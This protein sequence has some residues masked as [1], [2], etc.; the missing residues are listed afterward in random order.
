MI[1]N[2]KKKKKKAQQKNSLTNG[3]AS[4]INNNLLFFLMKKRVSEAGDH[5]VSLKV[6][7]GQIDLKL[8]REL[9]S[10]IKICLIP[11]NELK[12]GRQI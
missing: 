12:K 3:K 2:S 5:L 9:L 8:F 6:P 7:N 1:E 10:L 11:G 4:L